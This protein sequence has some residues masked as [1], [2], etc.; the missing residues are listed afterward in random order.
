M[1]LVTTPIGRD[2]GKG[3]IRKVKFRMH[4]LT[5]ERMAVKILDKDIIT[6]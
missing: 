2:I 1:I 5:G 4:T 3:T 6:M